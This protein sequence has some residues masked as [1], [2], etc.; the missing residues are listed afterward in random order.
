MCAG[1]VE[2]SRLGPLQGVEE[3]NRITLAMVAKTVRGAGPGSCCTELRLKPE[4]DSGP[5]LLG[6]KTSVQ[7]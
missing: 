1:R 2:S 5:H 4:A 7:V 6:P 3:V